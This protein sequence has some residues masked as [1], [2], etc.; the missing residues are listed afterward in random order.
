MQG[1]FYKFI[2]RGYV[3]HKERYISYAERGDAVDWGT[4]LQAGMSRVLFPVGS[5]EFSFT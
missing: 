3:L 4:A 1:I 5:L 2:L